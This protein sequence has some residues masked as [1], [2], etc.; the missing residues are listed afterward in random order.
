MSLVRGANVALTREIPTLTSIVVGVRWDAGHEEALDAN[1]VPATL[2][3][4]EDTR[5]LS[6][7]HF[8]FFNQLISP[9]LSVAQLQA[10]AGGDRE[11]VEI[12]LLDVPADVQNMLFVIYVNDGAGINRTLG[13]LR[14]CSVRILNAADDQELVASEDLASGLGP[15]TALV[16]GDLYRHSSGWKFRVVGQ[17]YDTG[18]RGV[19][20]NHGLSL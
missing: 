18:L 19:A 7:E 20:Q 9:D 5:L 17:G 12:D 14:S 2:M 8:I 13:Q 16:L 10:A 15:E 4:D 6:P 3:C 1:I 11:Q